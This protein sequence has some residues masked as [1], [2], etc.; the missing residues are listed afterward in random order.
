[1]EF[2]QL[3][4]R[5]LTG[6]GMYD[7]NQLVNLPGSPHFSRLSCYLYSVI[8]KKIIAFITFLCY[9][10]VT[11]GVIV[12]F[13]YCMNRLNSTQFFTA[14]SKTCGKCG[15][16][17][18]SNGC[19]KD[20]VK[21]VKMQIDQ[22]TTSSISFE[23]PAFDALVIIPSEFISAAFITAGYAKQ[24]QNHSPPLLTGQ[25]TYLNNCVFKI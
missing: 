25:D 2:Y 11:C 17:T 24:Y 23:L 22:K 20:K 16:H 8:M 10:A 4:A 6:W 1:L 18:D 21:I 9:F 7:F 12:N 3:I 19:C 5:E 13:H 15:M 14:E